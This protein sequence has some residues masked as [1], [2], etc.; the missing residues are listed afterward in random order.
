MGSSQLYECACHLLNPPF[1]G[2]FMSGCLM[3][4]AVSPAAPVCGGGDAAAH[5][6]PGHADQPGIV[7]EQLAAAGSCSCCKCTASCRSPAA[8]WSSVRSHP[9]AAQPPRCPQSRLGRWSERRPSFCVVC[10]RGRA[11]G[12]PERPWG[13][14][15]GKNWRSRTPRSFRNTAIQQTIG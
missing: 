1:R 11:A 5:S 7:M 10:Q 3:C 4:L 15:P 9:I 8:R 13:E 14:Y 2:V 6:W 12:G